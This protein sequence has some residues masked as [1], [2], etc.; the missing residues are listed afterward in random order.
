M[1]TSSTSARVALSAVALMLMLGGCNRGASE[2]GT[3][4]SGASGTTGST[5]AGAGAGGTSSGGTSG[6]SGTTGT[7]TA[8]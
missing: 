7:G 6:T 3:A 8:K 1:K 5:G 4:G 2:G